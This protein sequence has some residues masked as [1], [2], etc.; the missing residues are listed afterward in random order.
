MADASDSTTTFMDVGN[1]MQV[2]AEHTV[3]RFRE[4]VTNL[5]QSKLRWF[6]NRNN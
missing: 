2:L 1:L 3:D 4:V 5:L 6:L